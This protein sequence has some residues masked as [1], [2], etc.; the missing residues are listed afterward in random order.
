MVKSM[1]I[2]KKKLS[3]VYHLFNFKMLLVILILYFLKIKLFIIKTF[4]MRV[5]YAHIK[6]I[7]K[8]ICVY[9]YAI[10][11]TVYNLKKNMKH[12]IYYL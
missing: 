4:K 2:I 5:S 9:M 3:L 7:I 8:K 6:E 1:K 11:S 10:I 12:D